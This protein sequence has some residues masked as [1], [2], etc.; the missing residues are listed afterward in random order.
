MTILSDRDLKERLEK[1]D[2]I[3]EPLEKNQIGPAS[4]DVRLGNRIRIFKLTDHPLI[5]PTDYSDPVR[6]MRK[7]D[8]GGKVVMHEY[9]DLYVV[10]KPFVLHPHDFVLCSALERIELPTDLAARL[11]GRSSLGRIGLIVHATA[12]WI[13]PGFKGNITLEV[14]NIGKLPVKLY[15]G[16][17]AGQLIFYQLS[18]PAQVPYDK[19]AVSKYSQEKGATESKIGEDEEFSKKKLARLTA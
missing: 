15:P 12:G 1:G 11:D 2:L 19:R 7:L 6:G 9:T 4:V 14:T 5:D 17:R 3:I 10:N 16:M 13:D 18:S 8:S